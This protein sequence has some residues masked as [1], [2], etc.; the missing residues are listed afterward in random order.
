MTKTPS[1]VGQIADENN[2]PLIIEIVLHIVLTFRSI[3]LVSREE[4]KFWWTS[5]IRRKENRA[6]VVTAVSASVTQTNIHRHQ[7]PPRYRNAAYCRRFTV[8]VRPPRFGVAPITA[9][10]DVFHKIKSTQ[11][12]VSRN[13]ARGGP[14]HD[15]RGSAH[16]ISWK[17]AQRFQR[18]ARGQTERQTGWSQYSAPLLGWSNQRWRMWWK[19]RPTLVFEIKIISCCS[20]LWRVTCQFLHVMNLN[21]ESRFCCWEIFVKN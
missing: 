5:G 1:K 21:F 4:R 18:Y 14:I 19:E 11:R 12:T 8:P 16:K 10:R 15:H 13:A 17:S 9:K 20:I 7:T 3:A 6:S 2:R